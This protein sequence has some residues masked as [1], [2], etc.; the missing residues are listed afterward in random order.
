MYF[1]FIYS[2]YFLFF[3]PRAVSSLRASLP[4][5][6]S[7]LEMIPSL[8]NTYPPRL[9]T[10]MVVIPKFP[11]HGF[12]LDSLLSGHLYK[13]SS[14]TMNLPACQYS[15]PLEDMW[16]T[17]LALCLPSAHP[18]Y[19]PACFS[20]V[21]LACLLTILPSYIHSCFLLAILIPLQSMCV[22]APVVPMP[23]CP[24]FCLWIT[25][26]AMCGA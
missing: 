3:L 5:S 17:C 21:L 22:H 12:V 13:N 8:G 14:L 20:I 15:L 7:Y 25:A 9:P 19:L 6:P 11:G 16:V 18:S 24:C 2:F 1:S 23:L 10:S 26:C 4:S